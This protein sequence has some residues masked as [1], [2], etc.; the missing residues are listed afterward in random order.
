MKP[1]YAQTLAYALAEAA[2]RRQHQAGEPLDDYPPCYLCGG[3]VAGCELATAGQAVT[4]HVMVLAPCGHQLPV[5][6]TTVA[7]LADDM[8]RPVLDLAAIGGAA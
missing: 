8:P 3:D 6:E 1:T 2:R 4:T 5:D 7:R